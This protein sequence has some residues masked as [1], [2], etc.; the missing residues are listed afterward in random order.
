MFHKHATISLALLTL[1][2]ARTVMAGVQETAFASLNFGD[3]IFIDTPTSWTYADENLRKYFAQAGDKGIKSLGVPLTG[4][5]NVVLFAARAA[6]ASQKIA[7]ASVRLSVRLGTEGSQSDVRN[8]A[9]TPKSELESELA[10]MLDQ[11]TRA[12]RSLDGVQYARGVDVKI[13]TNKE[14]LSCFYTEIERT[15]SDISMLSQTWTCP[16]GNKNIKLSTSFRKAE[17]AKY[18]PIIDRIWNSLRVTQ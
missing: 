3:S 18:R 6:T 9:N 12:V 16:L 2:S 14:K 5:E 1:L 11:T 10:S 15:A 17:S 4:G 13:D 8:L 7:V